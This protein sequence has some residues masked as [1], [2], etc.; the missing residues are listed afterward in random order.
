[1]WDDTIRGRVQASFAA[2]GRPAAADTFDRVSHALDEWTK[3]WAQEAS[4]ACSAENEV[5][6][7]G[8]ESV[9]LRRVCLERRLGEVKALANLFQSADP[10]IV[11]QATNA[12]RGLV[13]PVRCREPRLITG[14]ALPIADP[15]ARRISDALHGR[16][17]RANAQFV[18]GQFPL[19][20]KA[21]TDIAHESHEAGLTALEAEAL[22]LLGKIQGRSYKLNEAVQTL[23]LALAAAQKSGSGIDI[24][25][26]A[27]RL[28]HVSNMSKR[29]DGS[30][31]AIAVAEGVRERLGDDELLE[32]D[33]CEVKAGLASLS[34]KFDETLKLRRRTLELKAHKLGEDHPDSIAALMNVAKTLADTGR[35]ARVGRDDA[36]GAQHLGAEPRAQSPRDDRRPLQPLLLLHGRG[37]LPRGHRAVRGRRRARRRASTARRTRWAAGAWG[38]WRTCTPSRETAPR[39]STR[40][41]ARWRSSRSC[42]AET[43]S[44]SPRRA[45]IAPAR[46]SAAMKLAEARVDID[47]ALGPAEKA[48]G[49]D[50]PGFS[51]YLQVK[52]EVELASGE[53]KKALAPLEAVLAV[54]EKH[55]YNSDRAISRFAMARALWES[56]GDKVRARSL[57]ENALVDVSRFPLHTALKARI[58]KWLA[59]QQ[60]VR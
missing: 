46:S 28:A 7:T 42:S 22:H 18:S 10:G 32:A 58:E 13:A 52:G 40:A 25:L 56:G 2:T 6:G 44:S 59:E 9:L 30:A 14:A 3:S 53:P 36:P 24:F 16:L 19:A 26:A 20:M 45:C 33:L 49:K 50:D 29:P 35:A 31:I 15:K 23:G 11:D 38:T 54:R 1:M 17:D 39:R 27:V 55:S 4:S 34:Q 47:A 21:A 60:P 57:A 51:E 48:L 8:R 43:I 12:S 41:I 37:P 5:A